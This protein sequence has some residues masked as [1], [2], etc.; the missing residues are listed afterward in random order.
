[1]KKNTYLHSRITWLYSRN[2]HNIVNQ[3]YINKKNF[4][5]ELML[6]YNSSLLSY[7]KSFGSVSYL[8]LKNL[9]AGYFL[10]AWTFR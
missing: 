4:E 10:L 3:L 6:W 5:N 2:Q 9:E 7:N 8:I 1:M